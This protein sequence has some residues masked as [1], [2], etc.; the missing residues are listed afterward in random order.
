MFI[1]VIM[2]RIV[3]ILIM[4]SLVLV[5]TTAHASTES[6]IAEQHIKNPEHPRTKYPII[7]AHG[8]FGF[9]KI[10]FIEYFN[11]IP[12]YLRQQGYAVFATK[13]YPLGTVEN[14]AYE[15][16]QQVDTILEIT[17]A[18][19]V[20]IIGH[21]M[22]GL[23]ARYLVSMLDYD[24]R[25]ASVSMLS[26][27]NRGTYIADLLSKPI[28]GV[29]Q[30]RKQV[31]KWLGVGKD[32]SKINE[33]L[34]AIQNC[35]EAFMETFNQYVK[36]KKEVYYQSWAGKSSLTGLEKDT[37][38][39]SVWFIPTLPILQN[40]NGTND[41]LVAVSSAKWGVYHGTIPAD[42]A[43][44]VGIIF[45]DKVKKINLKQFYGDLVYGLRGKGF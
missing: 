44:L 21:S 34:T 29:N 18:E 39:V 38:K 25:V 45:G 2:K 15:L 36:D 6:F 8:I 43:N 35:S 37:D 19:K 42:H 4:F 9:K 5:Y 12:Q 7:L 10:L 30:I 14:R 23:D 24:D 1:G 11:Q 33:A 32:Q 26:T 41:G 20:N 31:F 3:F 40:R 27:P 17:G 13:V 22:G 28:A 16:G